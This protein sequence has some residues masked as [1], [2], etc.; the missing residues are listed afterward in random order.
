M[1]NVEEYARKA[2]E[3]ARRLS[4]YLSCLRRAKW[5]AE[6]RSIFERYANETANA[7]HV[8]TNAPTEEIVAKIKTIIEKNIGDM[9]ME[10]VIKNE[11]K[12]GGNINA[13]GEVD[14]QGEA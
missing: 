5:Q 13:D 3:V 9:K 6:R 10:E 11:T 7:L 12:E 4:V 8:L 2:G 1:V 14:S